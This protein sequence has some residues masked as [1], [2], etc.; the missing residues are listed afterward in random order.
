MQNA[1]GEIRRGLTAAEYFVSYQVALISALTFHTFLHGGWANI[2]IFQYNVGMCAHTPIF[3]TCVF[4]HMWHHK[5]AYCIRFGLQFSWAAGESW[6][7]WSL[8]ILN[9]S[10]AAYTWVTATHELMLCQ[11]ADFLC[12]HSTN[13]SN[14]NCAGLPGFWC[15]GTNKSLP[16]SFCS[17]NMGCKGQYRLGS[18]LHAKQPF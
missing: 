3:A 13:K 9:H 8:R 15:S 18:I 12:D 2:Y 1:A 5:K 11:L 10:E 6:K 14:K 16:S 4:M 17:T 7:Q